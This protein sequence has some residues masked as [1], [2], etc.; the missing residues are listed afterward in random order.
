MLLKRQNAETK[1]PKGS[2]DLSRGKELAKNTAIL[3]FGKVCTQFI[4]FFLLPLYTAILDTAEYGTYDLLIT[5]AT[6]LL[7]LFNWQL[8]QGVFRF[9]LEV[10]DNRAGQT[11]LFSTIFSANTAQSAAYVAILLLVSKFVDLPNV[12]FLAAYVVALIYLNL[13][14]QFARGQGR[15]VVYAVAGFISASA[16][17]VFNVITLVVL[18]LGLN[19]LYISTLAAY[20]LAVAYLFFAL[21]PWRYL[22]IKQVKLSVLKTVC[23][24][25]LPLIP[26]NLAWWVVNV[27]DRLIVSHILGVGQNGIY[28]VANKFSN[29]FISFYNIFNLSWT[30][31]VSLHY[32]DEDRDRFLSETITTLYKLFSCACLGIVAL[33]P[34][35]FPILIN[36]S[37]GEAYPQ[38]PIL[39]YAMLMR[40]IVGLYSCIYI[41][42]KN[43]KKVAY[44]SAAA[45]VI[46]IVLHLLL[47]NKIGLFAA[48]ISTFV[49]F[50]S[51][52]VIRYIDVNRYVKMKISTPVL[53]S[54]FV[55]GIA[56]M[57][58]YYQQNTVLDV[59]FLIIVCVYAVAM[60]WKF[61]LKCLAEAKELLLKFKNKK[62][63]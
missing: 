33:M 23:R 54:S 59:I 49:A 14:L 16:T 11:K 25:S 52:A 61:G 46:N 24:Y 60:N 13:L 8:D 30:E 27:S 34:F 10:R 56:L 55:L 51:M 2:V 21:K 12:W 63:Q 1:F 5:Y 45:A 17:V 29:V 38:V 57:I 20:F 35:I 22:R 62:Q 3:T 42:M 6:L 18:K 48:S 58:S 41:A 36:E 47:I 44:T 9:M 15:N 50:G 39:M 19:G 28:T 40:V 26:N 37:Y 4:S 43:T 53:V 31:S 7:P 32:Q